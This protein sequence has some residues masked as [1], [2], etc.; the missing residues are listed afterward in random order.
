MKNKMKEYEKFIWQEIEKGNHSAGLLSFHKEMVRCFQHERLIHLIITLFFVVISLVTISI[1]VFFVFQLG[2][3]WWVMWPL[4]AATTIATVLAIA[5]VKYYYFLENHTQS[6]YRA[7]A[8]L[9]GFTEVKP[10]K[11]KKN[12]R[13]PKK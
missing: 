5:Y 10:E 7:T 11:T 12:R 8:I 4:Y 3:D 13:S 2:A 6:L 9:S 1:S